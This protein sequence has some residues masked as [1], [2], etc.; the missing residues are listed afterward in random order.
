MSTSPLTSIY[1]N[2]NPFSFGS[3]SETQQNMAE[4]EPPAS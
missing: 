2:T 4:K 1:T 3:V